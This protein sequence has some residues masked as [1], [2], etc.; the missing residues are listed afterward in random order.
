M[1]KTLYKKFSNLA[2]SQ[3]QKYE[4]YKTH[5]ALEGNDRFVKAHPCAFLSAVY[6]DAVGVC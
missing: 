4:S 3:T 2:L 1:T 6:D 5:Q